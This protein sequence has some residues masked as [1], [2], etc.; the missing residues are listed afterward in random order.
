MTTRSAAGLCTVAGLLTAGAFAPLSIPLAAVAGVALLAAALRATTARTR[1]T[2]GLGLCFAVPFMFALIGWMQAVSWSAYL[3]LATFES[4]V[5]AAGV[6]ALH[7]VIRL[8]GWP[9]LFA[10]VWAAG[11]WL[12][13][14][15]PF[16]GFPWGRL[17]GAAIDTPFAPLARYVGMATTSFLMA[18]VAALVVAALT[19]GRRT[20]QAAVVATVGIALVGLA[21][22][23]GVAGPAG[24]RQVALIQG[25]VPGAFLSWGYGE[26][27]DNHLVQ[28]RNYALDVAAGR[29]SQPDLVLWPENATD[30]D[31]YADPEVRTQLEALTDVLG[32]PI[33]VGGIFNGPSF[34][35]PEATAVN[36]GVV[37]TSDGPGDRYVKRRPVPFG[38]Y[39]PLRAHLGDLVPRFNRDIP[40]DMVAGSAAGVLHA[41]GTTWG[42]TICYDIAYDG[43]VRDLAATGALVVQ[44][45]NAAFSGT[46]QPDQQWAISRMR[47]IETGR[48]VLVPSTN[49]ISGVIDATGEVLQKAPTHQAQIVAQE[50]TLSSRRTLGM[51]VGG[52]LEQVWILVAAGALATG[53]A[54][55]R[56]QA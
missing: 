51:M 48:Q 49:G 50:I 35:Q 22:P 56:R 36:A 26:I 25:D 2:F 44:T 10:A 53:V 43:V 4:L 41:A 45:S 27:L 42:D 52:W 29:T 8:R 17:A 39:V 34:D 30:V 20:R 19:G 21:L 28:T 24:T 14:A 18:L 1:G 31:P 16:G 11:E 23:V 38:E 15:F 33:L 13:G 5:I 55:R 54:A 12:R 46:A 7:L 32:A 47:A 3:A 37:W 9:V 6:V 40:R